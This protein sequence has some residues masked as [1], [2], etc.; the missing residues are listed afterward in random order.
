MSRTRE[1]LRWLRDVIEDRNLNVAALADKAGIAR[2]RLRTVLLGNEAMTVEELLSISEALE[3]SPADF[4]FTAPASPEPRVLPLRAPTE[5]PWRPEAPGKGVEA[6]PYGNHPRQLFELGFALG[7]DFLFYAK[8]DE[9]AESGVPR[10]VLARYT[11][12]D[13]AI[14][15][16][17][18]YQ[19]YNEPRYD[20]DAI[21][22]TLSFDALYD[23]R[24]PWTSIRQVVFFPAPPEKKPAEPPK[25]SDKARPKLR[26]VE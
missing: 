21:T 13:V 12:R 19:P 6:D 3:I 22:L 5:A 17:A 24:F 26:L 14:K 4:G 23:C 18:A 2:E 25:P 15:L 1:L 9:L 10:D 11:P 7:C 16:D 8:T 20:D